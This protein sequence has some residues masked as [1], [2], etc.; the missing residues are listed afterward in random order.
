MRE[1]V[2]TLGLGRRR[3][4]LFRALDTHCLQSP[5]ASFVQDKKNTLFCHPI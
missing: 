4:R 1:A 3:R 2:V 5:F